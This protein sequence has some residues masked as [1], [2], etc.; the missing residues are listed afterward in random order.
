MNYRIWL[1]PGMRVKRWILILFAG[2]LLTSLST[3]MALA[4]LYRNYTVPDQ[5]S[6][7]VYYGTLQF[8]PHPYREILVVVPG[9][10]VRV[11]VRVSRTSPA[12][13]V[14]LLAMSDCPSGR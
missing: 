6:E 5:F 14:Q 3:A 1:R 11:P 13:E 9:I 8:I 7:I 4:W 2:V 12:L 10:T